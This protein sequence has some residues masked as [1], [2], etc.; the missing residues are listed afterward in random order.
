MSFADWLKNGWLVAHKSSK[1][2]IVNLLEIMA[3]DLNNSQAKKASRSNY[4]L[5]IVIII[6]YHKSAQTSSTALEAA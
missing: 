1:Q 2:E 4:I 5:N 6:S 3:R